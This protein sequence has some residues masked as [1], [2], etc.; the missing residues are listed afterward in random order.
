MNKSDILQLGHV[1]LKLEGAVLD[2]TEE[3]AVAIL[4]QELEVLEDVLPAVVGAAATLEAVVGEELVGFLGSGDSS[5][6][7]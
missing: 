4:V 2:T 7:R 3:L 1:P 5:V 6:F